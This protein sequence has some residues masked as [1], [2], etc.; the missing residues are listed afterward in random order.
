MIKIINKDEI[1]QCDPK[2][3]DRF[4]HLDHV[5]KTPDGTI[6]PR[7]DRVLGCFRLLLHIASLWAQRQVNVISTDTVTV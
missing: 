6:T 7:V 2:E 5:I 1:P 4:Q 3:T